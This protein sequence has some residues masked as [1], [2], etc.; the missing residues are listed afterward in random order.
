MPED[1]KDECLSRV[2]GQ[3]PIVRVLCAAGLGPATRCAGMVRGG[4]L[5]VNGQPLRDP[6]GRADPFRD[7]ITLDREPLP[8]DRACHYLMLHKPFGVLCAFTDPAGRP[9]LADYVDVPGVYAAGRLDLDSEGLVLLTGDGWLIHRLSHPR[10]HQPKTYLVQ[11]ERIPDAKA[12]DA[13]RQGV[14]TKGRRTARATAELLPERPDLPPRSK[15]IR[16][17]QTVP[18]AWLRIVLTEGRKR[19]V[20]HMTASVG[21]PTLR[22][23]R[24]AIGPL[25]LGDLQ[26]GEWRELS[27][28]EL[29]AL[30]QALHAG[31]V[32]RPRKHRP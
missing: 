20:R 9:T 23:V 32:S 2:A 31:T 25:E 24:V 27:P 15:P 26:P 19:Q 17:R 11:V 21:H 13:L 16:Q 3:Q 28:G 12:L 29:D 1:N 5:A 14:V 10:Y 8:L 6:R 18:T 30:W 4:R 7:L 22:L